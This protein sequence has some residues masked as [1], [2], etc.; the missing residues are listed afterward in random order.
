MVVGRVRYLKSL[1]YANYAYFDLEN[2]HSAIFLIKS[3]YT[4]EFGHSLKQS[5]GYSS[6]VKF[7]IDEI[8]LAMIHSDTVRQCRW[9]AYPLVHTSPNPS[10]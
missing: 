2:P 5:V 3:K 6:I 9:V 10:E 1:S 7:P 4:F 8:K